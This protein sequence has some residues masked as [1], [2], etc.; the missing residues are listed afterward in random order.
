MQLERSGLDRE[1]SARLVEA[2]SRDWA[3]AGVSGAERA[4]LDFAVRLT[5]RPGEIG[6]DDV[7]ALRAAGFEDRAIHD[8]CAV[9]AYFNFVNRMA[10]GLGVELEERF[11]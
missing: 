7:L 10:M 1:E 6:E 3:S 4:M 11:R 2:V 8:L 9:V 5:T